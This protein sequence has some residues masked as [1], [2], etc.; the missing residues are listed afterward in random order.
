MNKKQRE[1]NFTAA[2]RD[3]FERLN[4]SAGQQL[5]APKAGAKPGAG[6]AS[7]LA[8]RTQQQS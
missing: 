4:R 1:A 5:R 3:E 2:G 8:I 7:Q 6:I